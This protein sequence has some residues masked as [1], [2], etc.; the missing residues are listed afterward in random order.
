MVSYLV[1]LSISSRSGATQSL[2]RRLHNDLPTKTKTKNYT[3][4]RERDNLNY[5]E[6]L[7]NIIDEIGK[8]IF[9]IRNFSSSQGSI[10]YNAVF[11]FLNAAD[12]GIYAVGNDERQSTSGI[13]YA[14]TFNLYL[15]SW[16]L[17]SSSMAGTISIANN[18]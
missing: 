4:N 1:D 10:S 17:I 7:E 2:F 11:S 15:V 13:V 9:K 16:H 14:Y 6:C 12:L 5:Q 18:R 8:G 3:H